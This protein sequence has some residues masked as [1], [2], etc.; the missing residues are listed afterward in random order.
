MNEKIK[1]FQ[2]FTILFLVVL[3][4]FS[5][6]QEQANAGL[7]GLVLGTMGY[8]IFDIGEFAVSL[9]MVIPYAIGIVL[10]GIVGVFVNIAA[11]FV[12]LFL[13]PRIYVGDSSALPNPI[14]GVLT[15]NS[16]KIGWEVVRDICNMFFMFFLLIVAFGTMLRSKSINIKAILPKIIISLFLINFSMVFAYL[17]IDIS[18]FFM[19]EISAWMPG[20]FSMVAQSLSTIPARFKMDL[21]L[22]DKLTAVDTSMLINIIFAIG[23]SVLLFFVYLMLALFLMIRIVYFAVLI[24]FSPVAFLGIA[25][26]ALS[27][28]SSEWWK[29]IT[30]WAIFGPVFIFF[31]YLSVTMA[32]ELVGTVFVPVPASFD[33]FYKVANIIIPAV[34]P[35]AILLMAPSFATKSGVAG[36]GTLVGG[37]GGLGNIGMGAYG[38]GKWGYGKAKQA[39]KETWGRYTAQDNF[40]GGKARALGDK[41]GKTMDKIPI[42]GAKRIKNQAEESRARRKQVDE[43]KVDFSEL[44]PEQMTTMIKNR[45]LLNPEGKANDRQAMMEVLIDRN[46]TSD[47]EWIKAGYGKDDGS[48]T[49]KI[50]LDKDKMGRDL[51]SI[52][53]AGGDVD[54]FY[55]RRPDLIQKKTSAETK[56][57]IE[58]EIEKLYKEGNWKKLELDVSLNPVADNKLRELVGKKEYDSWKNSH[59]QKSQDDYIEN[60]ETEMVRRMNLS[61]AHQDYLGIGSQEVQDF[62]DEAAVMAS[63]DEKE[64]KMKNIIGTVNGK[65]DYAPNVNLDVANSIVSKTSK[66]QLLNFD[67]K[68]L[69]KYGHLLSKSD[70]KHVAKFGETTQMDAIKKALTDAIAGTI[71]SPTSYRGTNKLT[72]RQS[73]ARRQA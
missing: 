36:A 14:P 13:D 66:D 60:R 16:I 24:I 57:E 72:D 51:Q 63:V 12:D 54:D 34:V 33:I 40:G 38:A 70:I 59:S 37:R 41:Y 21:P 31:V 61:P 62:R 28:Y 4:G 26:P 69:E 25:F 27:R 11:W 9:F 15:S 53:A 67:D 35:I 45:N 29:E 68:F 47:K 5:I 44:K 55:K 7:T 52:E 22:L 73:E 32:N 58:G 46:K 3:I 17:V 2:K 64:N 56:K 18:Q 49:G 1:A 20:G 30:K 10:L 23:F 48:G 65:I 6:P 39:K 8:D 71:A 50:V 19:V 42:L 43:I